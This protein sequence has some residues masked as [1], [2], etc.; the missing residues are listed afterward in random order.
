VTDLDDADALRA[1]DPGRMLD[2]ILALHAHCREGYALGLATEDLPSADDVTSVAVCAMGGSAIAGDVI[3]ALYADRL[4]VPVTVVRTPELPEHLGPHALVVA[5]S[6]S[7]NTAETLTLFEEAARRGC[8]LIAV[9]SGGELARRANASGAAVVVIPPGFMPR[10]AFGY[11][12]LGA[13]GALEAIGLV[14]AVAPDLEETVG[15][16]EREIARCGPDVPAASNPAKA[17]A[18]TIGERVPVIWAAE[19]IGAVAASRWKTQFNENAKVPAFW[20]ALP[21]LDH[22]EVVGWSRGR[23]RDFFL[24]VLRHGGEHQDVAATFPLSIEVARGSGMDVEEVAAAG[25]SGLARLFTLALRGDLVSTY[26]AFARGVD[27]SPIDAIV[28]I[29]RALEPSP[30][31]N[32]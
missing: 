10:A 6:Y 8:R 14:P 2:T 13:L 19:G 20:A 21:E 24:V 28:S 31:S 23:G 3:R 12:T 32:R 5:S 29:K 18:R 1:A 11:L 9:A 7:G 17:L 27:P 30:A 16:L 25:R 22:N 26:L 4:H 15:E